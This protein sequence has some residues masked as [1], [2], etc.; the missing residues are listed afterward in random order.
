MY[1]TKIDFFGKSFFRGPDGSDLSVLWTRRLKIC[2][3][4]NAEDVV[5]VVS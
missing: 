1:S 2:F 3:V 4:E 5:G